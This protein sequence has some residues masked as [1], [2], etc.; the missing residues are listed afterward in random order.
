MPGAR[1]AGKQGACFVGVEPA[2]RGHVERAVEILRDR[3]LERR[4]GVVDVHDL[5]WRV[6]VAHAHGRVTERVRREQRHDRRAHD[7][8]DAQPG[9]DPVVVPG[10]PLR[11]HPLAFGVEHRGQERRARPQRRVFGERHGI[12][13]PRAVHRGARR[14]HELAHARA[15]CR[16]EEAAGAV[17]VDACEQRLVEQRTRHRGE[18]HDRVRSP[19][20]RQQFGADD[21]DAVEIELAARGARDRA[22]RGPRP[23]RHRGFASRSGSNRWPSMPE[24][25][26]TA[27]TRSPRPFCSTMVHR[28]AQ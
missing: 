2:V 19:H 25:P 10:G 8:R 17:D 18:M 23:G 4:R 24:T 12:V 13:R 28:L 15:C 3:E 26:V 14:S 6:R 20:I 16:V 21:V 22:R 11:E 1:A 7:G 5:H 27:T 9:C